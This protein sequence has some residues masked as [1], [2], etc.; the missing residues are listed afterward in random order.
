MS[1]LA[2]V[3][4]RITQAMKAHDAPA[5]SA[6]RMLKTA[7]TNK[8]VEKGHAL[9]DTE[10]LQVVAS[11][12]KQRRESIEQFGKGGRTDLVDKEQAELALLEA[13][14]PPPLSVAEIEDVVVKVIAETGATSPKEM[15]RVMKAA[16]A[17]LAGKG[18]DGKAV[19]EAVRRK[20]GA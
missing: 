5:L 7:L 1:M 15:G 6:M 4:A 17:A 14:T 12:I 20:L 11:L 9:D 2:D 3:N 13:M 8:E 18:V 19:N 16:M 10:S